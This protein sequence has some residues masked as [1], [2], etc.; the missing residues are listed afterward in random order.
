MYYES[1]FTTIL[2]SLSGTA[3]FLTISF[4][5]VYSLILSFDKASSM[6][7]SCERPF[8][9]SIEALSLPLTWNT[10]L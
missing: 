10:M 8:S 2:T 1:Y 5:A 9:T 7:F 4:P 6:S 3:I